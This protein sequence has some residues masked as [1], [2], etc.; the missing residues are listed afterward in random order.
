MIFPRRPLCWMVARER[1]SMMRTNYG[2][3]GQAR[4]PIADW[5]RTNAGTLSATLGKTGSD[6]ATAFAVEYMLPP[7]NSFDD[8]GS[9]E[10]S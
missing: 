5:N 6:A 3:G 1:T 10:G 7:N 8:P 2:H 4:I 9:H